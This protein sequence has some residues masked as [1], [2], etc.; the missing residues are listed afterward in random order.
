MH[1]VKNVKITVKAI[2]TI[3][4][5]IALLKNNSI[6]IPAIFF[7]KYNLTIA[8]NRDTIIEEINME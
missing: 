4:G 8:P 6:S 1:C 2:G 7:P 5:N 3:T